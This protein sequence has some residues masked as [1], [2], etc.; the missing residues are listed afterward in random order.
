[1]H[2]PVGCVPGGVRGEEFRLGRE[3]IGLPGQIGVGRIGDGGI[4]R[5]AGFH[6]QRIR[7]DSVHFDVCNVFLHQ[8]V[9]GNR[10]AEPVRAAW[11]LFQKNVGEGL[12]VSAVIFWATVA[13]SCPGFT[14][15][16][17]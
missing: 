9:P 16:S 4:F 5:L 10:L 1:L 7:R 13:A 14:R 15:T 17:T 3:Q 11:E 6:D 2:R 8:L 12:P